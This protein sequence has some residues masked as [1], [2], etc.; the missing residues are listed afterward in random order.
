MHFAAR[1]W[2]AVRTASW[3][4]LAALLVAPFARAGGGDPDDRETAP[5]TAPSS[6][7][8]APSVAQDGKWDVNDPPGPHRD[9]TLDVR[10][11][12]WMA[13]DVSP[14]G[15]EIVFDL[16]GDLYLLPIGGGEAKNLTHGLAY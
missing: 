5:G 9:V 3:L 7:A 13:L 8:N 15:R 11:G 12:T 14:D 2:S 4:F 16:L 1:R 10:T 6:G